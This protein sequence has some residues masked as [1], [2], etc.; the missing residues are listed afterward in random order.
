MKKHI[1]IALLAMLPAWLLSSCEQS[2]TVA[3][4]NCATE[5]ESFEKAVPVWAEGRAAETNLYLSFRQVFDGS[6]A[7]KAA[8]RLAAST[9][10]RLKMNGEFV[11]HGP[12]VCAHGFY[13][14]DEYDLTPW[15][16]EGQNVLSVEV[17]GYNVDSYYLLKQPSFLQAELLVDGKVVASTG[18]D[19]FQAYELKFRRSESGKLSFQRATAEDWNLT[20]DYLEWTT[21]PDWTGNAVKLEKQEAKNL[22][23]RGCPYPDYSVHAACEINPTL[24][25]FQTNSSGF[26]GFTIHVTE[27]THLRV[28]FDEILNPEGHVNSG[29]LGFD[30]RVIYDLAPGDYTLESFEPYTMQYVEFLVESG[31]AT[32]GYVYMRDYCGSAV[33]RA[34]FQSDNEVLNRLFEAARETHRQNAVDVFMDCPSRER[35]GWLCD[36]Y[37]SSRVAFDMAGHTQIEHNFLE[38]FLLPDSFPEVDPGM[39]PMCYPSDHYNHNHIPNWAMWFVMELEEYLH[40][41]GDRALIDQARKRVY[42]LVDYFKP[43]LNEDGLLEHLTRW[44]FIEWSDAANFTQDVNYPSNMLYASMLEVIG[45]L[46]DDAELL[47]QAEQVR[48]TVRKQSYDGRFFCDNAVRQ[49]DGTLK[50]TDNHTEACQYYAFYLKTATPDLYPELWKRLCEEFGPIRH[51]DNRYPDVPFANAFIGNYLRLEALS[52]QGLSK[53]L[54]SE[55]IAE[56]TKMANLTGTLWENMG[57]YASCNHGFAA[58]IEHV[59][60]RDILGVYDV[61][62][63]EK[64][65]TLRFIDAGLKHCK[66]VIPVGNEDITVEWFCTDGKFEYNVDLP[67]GWKCVFSEK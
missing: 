51:T 29:R 44:V 28:N 54:L 63:T 62:P 61:S 67:R 64:T 23:R 65:V 43:F 12:S 14:I 11:G 17:A 2:S 46:Y 15:M 60:L 21:N 3:E 26:L 8:I 45:K 32:V 10:F 27:Q 13:R 37:F 16:K 24:F 57:T 49:E 34:K 53:Q 36:S 38:N 66:G 1:Y 18:D 41:S 47:A 25:K 50:R 55:C 33:T 42:E 20:P 48:E 22:L 5:C 9:N 7:K 30:A 52:Q 58:H 56:Y 4:E 19:S 39:L 31:Q 40:R 6:K 59:L 35:A